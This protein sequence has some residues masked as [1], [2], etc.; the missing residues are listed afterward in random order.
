MPCDAGDTMTLSSDAI[1]LGTGFSH[2]PV[3]QQTGKGP[4]QGNGNPNYTTLE[5]VTCSI[6]P[7]KYMKC[8]SLPSRGCMLLCMQHPGMA[9]DKNKAPTTNVLLVI[10]ADLASAKVVRP[11]DEFIGQEHC[12]LKCFTVPAPK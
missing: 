10:E 4:W 7:P 3:G 2:E 1:A 6:N 11:S 9:S 5:I 8:L 12:A